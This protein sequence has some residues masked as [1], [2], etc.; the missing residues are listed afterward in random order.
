MV[1][2]LL[3]SGILLPCLEGSSF[4]FQVLFSRIFLTGYKDNF[5]FRMLKQESEWMQA[6][7]G[8]S[9]PSDFFP[10]LEHVIEM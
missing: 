9:I 4:F 6:C 2:L 7:G 5:H 3:L 8:S 10:S 1:P